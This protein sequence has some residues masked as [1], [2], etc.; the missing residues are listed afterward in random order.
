MIHCVVRLEKFVKLTPTKSVQTLTATDFSKHVFIYLST[1]TTN[2]EYVHGSKSTRTNRACSQFVHVPFG[3]VFNTR[4]LS[5]RGVQ[6]YGD[7]AVAAECT[8]RIQPPVC[9][10][11][12][13]GTRIVS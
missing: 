9:D 5:L 6:P 4:R 7:G 3:H 13:H 11:R 12:Q 8:E 2:W 1:C 10:S